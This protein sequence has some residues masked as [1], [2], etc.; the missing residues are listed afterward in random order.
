MNFFAQQEIKKAPIISSK[1]IK[2]Y[3]KEFIW[4]I[5]ILMIF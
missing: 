1:K 3:E 5:T 2:S 4:E